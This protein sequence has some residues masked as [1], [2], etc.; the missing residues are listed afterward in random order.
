MRTRTVLSGVTVLAG[1]ASCTSDSPNAPVTSG[2]KVTVC[3]QPSSAP[4]L[5]EIPVEELLAH[6]AQ[7][8]YVVH[9]IVS[10]KGRAG[11]GI[12]YGRITDAL[13]AARSLRLARN[14]LQT[15]S[16]RITI[17]V[18]PG[19]FTGSV[20]DVDDPTLERFP[21]VIDVPDI[22]IVGA[23]Q[24]QLDADGRATASE[25]TPATTLTPVTGLKNLQQGLDEGIMIVNG[26][27]N[28][29]AGN[30]ADIEGFAFQSGH[31]G[32]DNLK[33]GFGIFSLR[34]KGLLIRGNRFETNLTSAIDLRATSGKVEKNFVIGG[35]TCDICLAGPGTLI[36]SDNRMLGGGIDGILMQ[37]VVLFPPPSNLEPY[38]LPAS[39]SLTATISNN[40]VRDHLQKPAG[41]GVRL[42]TIGFGTPDVPTSSH[43]EI[44]NNKLFNNTFGVQVEAGFPVANTMLRGDADVSLKGNSISQSCQ[45]DL[46][47]VFTRHATALGAGQLT[48]PYV[49]HST[50]NISLGGDLRWEDAWYS[51]PAGFDNSLIVDGT[52][53]PN[54]ARLAYDAA[55]T[56][57]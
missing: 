3:H 10:K 36:A 49:R 5:V 9:L 6:W 13:A 41:V 50:Y 12:H 7:G 53:I 16:C 38:V 35:A 56:C 45:R 26:H 15:G 43:V 27:P 42:A 32:V 18:D 29:S 47:V 19:T 52:E 57:T 23:L 54:G 4:T 21:L 1:I 46:L 8:D 14:E 25:G 2:D 33:G 55:R 24:M 17:S 30:G 48:R 34:V 11:D 22:S 28:A 20:T 40:E 37:P 31:A 51:D 44:R 39:A